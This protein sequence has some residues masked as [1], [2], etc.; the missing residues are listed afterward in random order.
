M[1]APVEAPAASSLDVERPTTN[2][3][4]EL[5]GTSYSVSWGRSSNSPEDPNTKTKAP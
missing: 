4:P 3:V 5:H 2:L 1:G